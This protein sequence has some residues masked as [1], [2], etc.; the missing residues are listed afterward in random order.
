MADENIAANKKRHLDGDE[1]NGNSPS[2]KDLSKSQDNLPPSSK[3][4]SVD[5]DN[6]P[7]FEELDVSIASYDFYAINKKYCDHFPLHT[8]V[9]RNDSFAL[10]QILKTGVDIDAPCL[11]GDTALHIAVRTHNWNMID[12]LLKYGANIYAR[13]INK[14]KIGYTALHL[15]AELSPQNVFEH[16]L[17]T[18]PNFIISSH[19]MRERI[20]HFALLRRSV[21]M[22]KYLFKDTDINY[23]ENEGIKTLLLSEEESTVNPVTEINETPLFIAVKR[24]YLNLVKMLLEIGGNID[25]LANY[26]K[27]GLCS[28]FHVAADMERKDILTLLINH[29]IFINTTTE[30]G[31][32]AVHFAVLNN[33]LFLTRT[34]VD[35][36]VDVNQKGSLD[37][38]NRVLTPLHIAVKNKNFSMIELLISNKNTDV[39]ATDGKNKSALYM[40]VEAQSLEV[41]EYLLTRSMSIDINLHNSE[42]GFTALHR[43][44]ELNNENMIDLLIKYGANLNVL[45][46]YGLSSIHIVVNTGNLM[47]VENFLNRGADVNFPTKGLDLRP[48]H[49]AVGDDNKKMVQLLLK[50]GADVDGL[51]V[52]K[53]PA[54]E[55][56]I[57]HNNQKLTEILLKFGADINLVKIFPKEFNNIDWILKEHFIKLEIAN[58]YVDKKG[59]FYYVYSNSVREGNS[60]GKKYSNFEKEIARLKKEVIKSTKVIYYDY[61]IKSHS[62]LVS[63]AR[64]RDIVDGFAPHQVIKKFPL[65]SKIIIKRF[66]KSLEHCKL[67]DHAEKLLSNLF[68]KLLPV[69]VLR[70]A[71]EYLSIDDLKILKS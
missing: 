50:K 58:M 23:I 70:Q 24:G 48:L 64:N 10:T 51:T 30:C 43:A 2:K 39:N 45:T 31:L 57:M 46:L 21:K 29:D 32:N 68:C 14:G 56:A 49:I 11:N 54:L 16:M 13:T 8:A 41:I 18:K 4:V 33:N 22:I 71:L 28:V 1:K 60:F 59:W 61:L 55:F 34:L 62:E 36:G 17:S 42:R 19:L 66:N 7:Q 27:F 44:L 25:I 65:Y 63:Y 6:A 12:C 26:G 67:L 37:Q 40:A 15:A 5:C 38:E 35:W 47:A 3:S 9:E 20:I 53:K 69:T 52:D